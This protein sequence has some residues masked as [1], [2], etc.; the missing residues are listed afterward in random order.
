MIEPDFLLPEKLKIDLMLTLML[1]S[2]QHRHYKVK[3]VPS[4]DNNHNLL[5]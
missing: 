4:N 3:T 1:I 2:E 5:Y